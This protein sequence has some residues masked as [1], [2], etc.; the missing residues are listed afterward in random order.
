MSL[1]FAGCALL[2]G[3]ANPRPDDPTASAPEPPAGALAWTSLDWQ[4]VT[5][6]QPTKTSDEQWDQATAVAA[7]PG[8]WVAVGS[9]SDVMGYEGRVWQSTDSLSWSLVNTDLVAGIELVSIAATSG[10]YVAIGTDSADPNHPM[11][12]ILSSADGLHWDLAETIDDAWAA[13]VAAGTEGFAVIVQVG[14]TTKLLLSSDGLTWQQVPDAEIGVDVWLADIAWDGSGWIAAGSSGDRAV[15]LRSPDGR[16]WREDA[17]PAS[18][19]TDGILDVSAYQVVPGRWATLLLGIDRGPSCAEDDDF[20]D[21]WQAAWSWTAETGWQRLPASTR[22]LQGGYGAEAYPA[23][24]AGFLYLLGNEAR[25]SADGWAWAE[26][27]QS[28]PPDAFPSDLIVYGDRVVAVGIP[29]RGD[30]PAGWFG[31]ALIRH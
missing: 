31:S 2:G 20:C 12:S 11:T 28:S 26:I 4:S 17:L 24:D 29:N 5:H 18:R 16:S 10:V 1:A 8:G 15:V 25:T 30:E 23:E 13:H 7:G 3:T 14:D 19:P 6:D 27:E 22:I 21:Q 9:N